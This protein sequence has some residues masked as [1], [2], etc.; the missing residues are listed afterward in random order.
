MWRRE[1]G[2]WRFLTAGFLQLDL[3]T[4]G[5]YPGMCLWLRLPDGLL[6]LGR[7]PHCDF[8]H[9]QKAERNEKKESLV[10]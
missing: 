10:L 3:Y 1:G 6:V 4:R 2:N 8:N 7:E 9:G 5:V